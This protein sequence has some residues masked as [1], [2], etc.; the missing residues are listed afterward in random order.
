MPVPPGLLD[1]LRFL[2][3]PMGY[4]DDPAAMTP[5][6]TEWRGLWTG[7]TPLVARPN[8]TQQV[9]QTVAACTEA[10]VALVPQGGHTGLCGG[11]VPAADASQVVLSLDRLK[12]IRALDPVDDTATVD[13][14]VVLADLHAAADA[15]DR[16]FP[17]SLAAAGSC[18]IGGLVSTNAGGVHVV[19]YGNMRDLVLGLEAVLPDGRVWNGLRALRKDNTGY[20]LKQLFI[21]AEGTLGI[22]TGAVLKLFPKPKAHAVALF[23]IDDP[24]AALALF[25]AA[26]GLADTWLTAAELLPRR[27]L[28]FVLDHIPGARDPL[29]AAHPWYLLVELSAADPEAPL[30]DLMMRLIEATGPTVRDAVLATSAAQ[31]AAL[32]AL[33]ENMSEAQKH[34]GISIK[35][36]VSVPVS[37]VPAFIAAADAAIAAAAPGARPTP[38]GHLGDGNIH[39]NVMQP[40]D[41]DGAAF[42]ARWREIEHVVHDIVAAHDGS[43]SAEHGIGQLKRDEL[44][45]RRS[46]VEM[47]L[48]R[49]IKQ[50][51]DP[52]N[53]MNPGKVLGAP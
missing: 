27:G 44:A 5:Y 4:I 18:Q 25:G 33:R 39:Y 6:V 22:V 43:I 53:L 30:D 9:A 26:K 45:A 32:W 11:A 10:G 21:G 14:G 7:R 37:R 24:A 35:H 1:R 3:G 19:R 38:F 20:A 31:A 15:A 52:N 40:T 17:L 23:A 12:R 16:L 34:E 51:V 47:D 2:L 41:A 36:D 28:D 8:S 46:P 48:M 42:E 50:A 13:A 29:A 49:A